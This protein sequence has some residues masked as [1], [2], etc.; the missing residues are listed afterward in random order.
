MAGPKS[1]R[2]K[3]EGEGEKMASAT[4]TNTVVYTEDHF[5]YKFDT[6]TDIVNGGDMIPAGEFNPHNI[7]PFILHD[8]GFVLGIVFA[9]HLQDAL[10]E[11]VNNDVLD[12]YQV[13]E[14]EMADYQT[15][16]DS[17]RNPEY[18][19]IAHLGNASEPF[20]IESL[21]V[22]EVPVSRWTMEYWSIDQLVSQVESI[23]DD[24]TP[25]RNGCGRTDKYIDEVTPKL[26]NMLKELNRR[27][28]E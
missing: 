17:E 14:T 7:H 15:G 2:E 6:E 1:S 16:V 12:R 26:A 19:G 25:T 28:S 8:A 27:R 13:T 20:D 5:E 21:D 22:V 11:A 4:K 23:L 24:L 18:E 9:E 10:D 3:A